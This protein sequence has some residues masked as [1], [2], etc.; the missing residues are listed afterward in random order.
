MPIKAGHLQLI[1]IK[2][3]L[4]RLLADVRYLTVNKAVLYMAAGLILRPSLYTLQVLTANNWASHMET[5]EQWKT[6]LDLY[7]LYL[8]F[9]Y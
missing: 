6:H 7:L 3:T 4:K 5:L 8:L 2:Q 9:M 1:I